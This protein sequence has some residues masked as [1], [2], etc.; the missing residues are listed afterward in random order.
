VKRLILAAACAGIVA[1]AFPVIAAR[2]AEK[3]DPADIRPNLFGAC[4]LTPQEGWVIGDRGRIFYTT[5][6]GKSF[7]RL[8]AGTT[9]A[10]LSIACFPDK[11][12]VV[13]GKSGIIYRSPDGGRTWQQQTSGTDRNLVAVAF[14]SPT[15]GLAVG[16]AGM[17]VRT[18]DAGVTWAKI[19]VPEQIPLP[20]DVAETVAPGD[21][22]FYDVTF[23]TPERAWIVGEFGVILTTTDGGLTWAAQKGP[24]QSTLF[25]VTFNDALHGWCVGLSAVM[26]H[27]QDGGQTWET[28]KVPVR[29]GFTLS[30]YALSV[31][32]DYG[33]AIGDSGYLLASK[34]AGTTWN[35]VDVPIQFAGTWFR[36][37]SL[38]PDGRG[39]IVGAGGLMLATDRVS[40]TLL[41]KL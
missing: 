24:V 33:W 25:G 12:L 15:T 7:E 28:V 4:F 17:I 34:D 20:E 23:P 32:G 35:L 2:S 39:L 5:D 16:D 38:T 40:F 30:L 13:V 9:R 26:L 22:L 37:L 29:P 10:F 19:A 31:R 6:G 1:W 18:Q 21:I 36:G 8:D 3:V 27:T 11:T 41:R 14:S